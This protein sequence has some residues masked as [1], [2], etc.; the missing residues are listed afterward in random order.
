VRY[1]FS[2]HRS[3]R[4]RYVTL[5]T[6]TAD[7]HQRWMDVSFSQFWRAKFGGYSFTDVGLTQV[8]LHTPPRIEG[9]TLVLRYKEGEEAEWESEGKIR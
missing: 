7:G 6:H 3:H 1:Y 8:Q 4:L 2:Y 5:G 9:N